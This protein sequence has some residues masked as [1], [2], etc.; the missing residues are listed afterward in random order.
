MSNKGNTIANSVCSVHPSSS[1]VIKASCY[2]SIHARTMGVKLHHRIKHFA[3]L[4][5]INRS[6]CLIHV[7]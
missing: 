5:N 3:K 1:R 6:D 2:E 7:H 4:A